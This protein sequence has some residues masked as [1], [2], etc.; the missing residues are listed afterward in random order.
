MAKKRQLKVILFHD[1]A[2]PHLTYVVKETPETLG[3]EVLSRAVY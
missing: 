3:W 1:N 2:Q